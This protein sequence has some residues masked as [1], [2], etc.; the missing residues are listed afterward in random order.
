MSKSDDRQLDAFLDGE[1]S[2]QE[3]R[4]LAQAALDDPDLFDQL[5]SAAAVNAAASSG[6][7]GVGGRP[8][9]I[10]FRW[11]LTG[12]AAAIVI[13]AATISIDRAGSR[14]PPTATATASRQS[15]PAEA[16]PTP[17]PQ[18]TASQPVILTARL[19]DLTGQASPEFRSPAEASR[20]PRSSGAVAGVENGEVTID[21]GSVDGVTKGAELQISRGT[22]DAR[23]SMRLTITTVFRERSRGR[24]SGPGSAQA[25]DRVD[26]PPD[27]QLSALLEQVLARS[28]AGDSAAA[29]TL[30]T[31]G[32]ELSAN[33]S[34]ASSAETMNELAAVLIRER[35][36]PAAETLLRRAQ[37]SAAGLTAVRVTNNLAAL[38]A[39]SGDVTTAESM[40]RSALDMAGTLPA[41]ES[42]R[43]SI[44][45][46]L[47]ALRSR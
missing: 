28:V 9:K 22:G 29:R 11:M 35:D 39:L 18:G 19:G 5:A 44:E 42:A 7:A 47:E 24:V 3:Q 23:S 38:A 14:R 17:T 41:Y 25:G 6:A 4:A 31:R 30:A 15:L 12:A 40:Y 21:L 36:Y 27:L 26:V 16:E 45:K 2:P 37:A 34:E 46:N 20:A 32:V 13:I 1:L 10:R 33:A 8:N 43:Q